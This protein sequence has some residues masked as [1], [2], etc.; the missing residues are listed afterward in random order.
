[1]RRVRVVE[2]DHL[3]A[4]VPH[5]DDRVLVSEDER[6]RADERLLHLVRARP[7]VVI[8][9]HADRRRLER[10]DD[11]VELVE[12]FL[13]VADEVARDDAEVGLRRVRHAHG[14]LVDAHRRDAA[15]VEIREVRDADGIHLVDVAGDSCE[16]AHVDAAEAPFVR[17]RLEELFE[18]ERSLGHE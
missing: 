17:G 3:K 12:E 6:A 7:V 13:A 15:D 1:M 11:L 5:V 10:A 2:P 14:L 16:A 9:E 18:R 4:L 8:A